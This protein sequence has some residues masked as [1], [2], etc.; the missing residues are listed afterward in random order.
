MR[1]PWLPV[2]YGLTA[3]LLVQ[4]I[5]LNLWAWH[6]NREINARRQAVT[7]TLTE[8]FPQVRAVLDAPVQMQKQLD[9]LRASAGSIGEQDL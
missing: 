1:K 7:A 2:R 3:L 6:Q 4:V 8:A 9:L 5:G